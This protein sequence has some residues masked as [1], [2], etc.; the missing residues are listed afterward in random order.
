[1]KRKYQAIKYLQVKTVQNK[2]KI[3]ENKRVRT[4]WNE[5]EEDWCFSV[6]DIC[7]V[8]ADSPDFTKARKYWNK[9]KQRLSKEG[10]ELVTNCHQL[11]LSARE[12]VKICSETK[13]F[14]NKPPAMRM[15]DKSL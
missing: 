15:R 13:Y 8:L 10:S 5:E 6:V 7:W 9:L 12:P 4:V 3:F 14:H 11:E 1:M 2:I